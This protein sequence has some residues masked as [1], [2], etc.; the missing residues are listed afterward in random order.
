LFDGGKSG[1]IDPH[2]ELNALLYP[3]GDQPAGGIALIE[4][5]E[6][7]LPLGILDRIQLE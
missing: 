5:L 4:M 2:A 1:F 3:I 7:H 6:Q